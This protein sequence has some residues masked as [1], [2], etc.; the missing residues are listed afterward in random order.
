[1]S[2]HLTMKSVLPGAISFLL[3]VLFSSTSLAGRY[4]QQETNITI[5][6]TLDDQ[7]NSI[8]ASLSIDYINHSPDTLF[9]ILMH[10]WANAYL[11]NETALARQFIRQ[12]NYDFHFASPRERGFYSNLNFNIDGKE[13]IWGAWNNHLDIA[14]LYLEN[15]LLPGDTIRINTPF[16]LQLPHARF[17]RLGHHNQSYYITQWYPKPAVYDPNGWN[18]MPYLHTGEFYSE[19]GNIEVFLTLPENYRVASSGILHTSS[20]IAFIDSIA[21]QTRNKTPEQLADALPSPPSSSNKNKTLHFSQSKVHDFAWFADKQFHILKDS[22]AIS[23]ENVVTTYAFFTHQAEFWLEANRYLKESIF[24]MSGML[25]PY[26]WQQMT[27][28]QGIHSE[29]ANMEYPAITLIGRQDRKRDLET[30]IVH[31]TIHNWFYGILATNERQEPWLDEG[32]TTYYEQRFFRSKYPDEMLLGNLSATLLADFFGLAHTR[33]EQDSWLMYQLKAARRL[34]QAINTPAEDFTLLNYYIMA[35]HKSAMAIRYL[36][37]YLGRQAFDHIM[38]NFYSIWQFKH[39]TASDLQQVFEDYA[40]KDLSWFFKHLIQSAGIIEFAITGAHLQD[41]GYA[42]RLSN[43]GDFFVPFTFSAIHKDGRNETLWIDKPFAKDTT[44]FI[45]GNNIQKFIIDYRELLP[46]IC[47]NRNTFRPGRILN[48]P[49]ELQFLGSLKNPEVR[50][51]FWT[52]VMGYNHNDGFLPGLALY[53]FFFPPSDTEWLLMPLY[54]IRKDNMKGQA[55]LYHNW[56]SSSPSLHSIR[57]GSHIKKYAT[58]PGSSAMAFTRLETSIAAILQAPLSSRRINTEVK[59]RHVYLERDQVVFEMGDAVLR[60]HNFHFT[61]LMFAHDNESGF[62]PYSFDIRL[63][64]IEDML[65]TS[66]TAKLFTPYNAR[67]DGLSLRFF[68]G[69]FLSKP[70]DTPATD[71]RFRLQGTSPTRDFAYDHIFVGR[72]QPPGTLW[73]HQLYETDGAFK[74]PTPLG[75]TW[76]WLTSVNLKLDIPRT[77]LRIFLDV[78]TYHDAANQIIG[79]EQFPY[80]AGIQAAFFKDFLQVNF[81]ILIS[82]DLQ[83]TAELNNISAFSEQITFTLR[84]DQANPF[85]FL[86]NLNLLVL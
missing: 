63:Q 29:G 47:R 84:L 40:Q 9:E 10:L 74:F 3:I 48:R 8:N 78:A 65:R 25:G 18:P 41:D 24:Y 26:P 50:Q 35:Y 30:V 73:G 66:F 21:V 68:A 43:K 54:S 58:A 28:V 32:F 61:E 13:L 6:A 33:K 57:V 51:I 38:R 49:P 2:K 5:H 7:S 70:G 80:V 14:V 60:K 4:F 31:E 17:S 44:I 22:I 75:Q 62:Y 23:A 85:H 15:P 76:H 71:M 12:G 42:V 11:D 39:P 1:M 45:A 81:P 34:D 37:Y 83:R 82:D 19:F 53:N 67:K 20:E 86:K 56:F 77:P 55:W 36:E 52:P 16:T 72:N 69:A 64:N 59:A 27:A 79:S 46:E